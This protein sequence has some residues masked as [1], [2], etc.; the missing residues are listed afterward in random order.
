MLRTLGDDVNLFLWRC[1]VVVL[2]AG[3]VISWTE[4]WW[5]VW[6]CGVKRRRHCGCLGVPT[7][8]ALP[9][10]RQEDQLPV[11]SFIP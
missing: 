9:S 11:F 10:G 8:C 6:A 3:R 2:E 5:V 4:L 1:L 7:D